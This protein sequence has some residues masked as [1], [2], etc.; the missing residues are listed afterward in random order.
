MSRDTK[1]SNSQNNLEKEELKVS[2][3]LTSDYTTELQSSKQCGT[4]TK[5]DRHT[6]QQNR[7]EA[8]EMNSYLYVQLIFTNIF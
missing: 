2:L 1:T 5:T 4:G 6:D 7:I 3:A 8:S